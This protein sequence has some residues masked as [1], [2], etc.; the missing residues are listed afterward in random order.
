M[1]FKFMGSFIKIYKNRGI[2]KTLLFYINLF[3]SKF[4]YSIKSVNI[5]TKANEVEKKVFSKCLFKYDQRGFWYLNPMP[6]L[7]D[8]NDY[9]SSVYWAGRGGSVFSC[10]ERDLRHFQ[11]LNELIP[12]FFK[13]KRTILNFGAGHGGISHILWVLGHDIINVEPSEIPNF[14]NERWKQSYSIDEVEKSSVDFVYGSHSLEHVQDINLHNSKIKQ[15]IKRDGYV[16]WEVPNGDHPFSG[17]AENRIHVPHTYYF[18]KKYFEQEFD[19]IILNEYFNSKSG[20]NVISNWKC[21]LGYEG[22]CINTLG[23]YSI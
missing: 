3:L 18:Q 7:K 12:D 13:K 1:L 10:E 21:H 19:H 23:K 6:S 4:G 22:D 11:I 20:S 9:Y 17:P 5:N 14:Y 15:I 16:F 2:K 8:L